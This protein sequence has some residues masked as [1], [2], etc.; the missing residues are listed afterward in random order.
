MA[1]KLFL[2]L[3]FCLAGLL[4]KVSPQPAM[5]SAA[6]D[7]LI[8]AAKAQY[9]L[10]PAIWSRLL[11]VRYSANQ[12]QHVYLVYTA[13][14]GELLSFDNTFGTRRFHTTSRDPSELARIVDSRA[15]WA[16][17]VEENSNNRNLFA[18]NP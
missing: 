5:A 10:D 1:K 13:K 15:S 17:Y 6:N 16:W 14:D 4:L 2:A 8:V 7:C 3:S 18:Q 11:V 9:Q 12:L